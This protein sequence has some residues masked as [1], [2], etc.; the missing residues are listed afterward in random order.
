MPHYSFPKSEFITFTVLMVGLGTF[1]GM[2]VGT[3][4]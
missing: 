1:I 2:I 4:L 3:V